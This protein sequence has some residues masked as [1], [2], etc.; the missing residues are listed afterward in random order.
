MVQSHL[1]TVNCNICV[2]DVIVSQTLS[3]LMINCFNVQ[4]KQKEK[5]THKIT[6]KNKFY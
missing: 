3:Y 2:K 5:K 4:A 1:R 6:P